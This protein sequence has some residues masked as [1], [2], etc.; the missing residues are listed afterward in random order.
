MMAGKGLIF[1]FLPFEQIVKEFRCRK[2]RF[3]LFLKE[4]DDQLYH[5][6]QKQ[7]NEYIFQTH[8]VIPMILFLICTVI[9]YIWSY[10]WS[11]LK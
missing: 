2:Q 5:L 1:S 4:P 8:Q 9:Y 10:G 6:K 7:N 11:I 3:P